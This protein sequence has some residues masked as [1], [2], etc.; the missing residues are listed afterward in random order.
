MQ[1]QSTVAMQAMQ[2]K[3][4]EI[5]TKYKGKDQQEMQVQVANLYRDAGVNP[6]AGCLP[7][8]ATLPVWIGLYR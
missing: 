7:T 8:L 3:I 4:E 2:P 6:L 1:V 5:K